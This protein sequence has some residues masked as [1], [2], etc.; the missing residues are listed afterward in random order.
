MMGSWLLLQGYPSGQTVSHLH[1][2]HVNKRYTRQGRG[3]RSER[4][5]GKSANREAEKN[6]DGRRDRKKPHDGVKPPHGDVTFE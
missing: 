5:V 6:A 3:A 2:G 1:R 4:G